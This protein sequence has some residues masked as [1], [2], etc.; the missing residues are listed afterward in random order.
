MS[1]TE[2]QTMN[3]V[4]LQAEYSFTDSPILDLVSMVI[5]IAK[6]ASGK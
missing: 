5:S 2:K 3:P 1:R 4:D 6:V